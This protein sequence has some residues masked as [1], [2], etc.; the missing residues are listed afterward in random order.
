[1]AEADGGACDTEASLDVLDEGFYH[2]K[3]LQ[4]GK[5]D[6]ATLIFYNFEMVE[7]RHTGLNA[8]YFSLKHWGVPDFCQLIYITTPSHFEKRLGAMR[9]LAMATRKAVDWI[10]IHPQ[11]AKKIYNDW[12]GQDAADRMNSDILDATLPMFPNDQSMPWEYYE[13]LERW[14][15]S[16]GQLEN[17]QLG[18]TVGVRDYWTNQLA[19]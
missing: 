15:G 2:T 1:M 18:S 5:A 4:D 3:A 13:N 9:A 11:E 12:T 16:T 7:A 10:K 17:S 8:S 6:A 19:L 14:L